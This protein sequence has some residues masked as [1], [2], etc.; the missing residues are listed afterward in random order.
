M[1]PAR[2]DVRGIVWVT[3]YAVAGRESAQRRPRSRGVK[4]IFL[5]TGHKLDRLLSI[6]CRFHELPG[7]LIV[8]YCSCTH[9]GCYIA[10]FKSLRMLQVTRHSRILYTIRI[11]SPVYWNILRIPEYSRKHSVSHFALYLR[12]PYLRNIV[13]II[14]I[15][16]ILHFNWSHTLHVD[17]TIHRL[18]APHSSHPWSTPHGG[19]TTLHHTAS[20]CITNIFRHLPMIQ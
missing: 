20:V 2:L 5:P 19:V 17:L 8:I 14:I 11:L 9:D 1:S 10:S 7:A 3:R 12:I 16:C 15:L 13:I 6:V 18:Q 4:V